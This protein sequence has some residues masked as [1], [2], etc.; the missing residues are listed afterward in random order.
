[1]GAAMV[2][3]M[4]GVAACSS[5][6]T[7]VATTD[8]TDSIEVAEADG[9]AS[10]TDSTDPTDGAMDSDGSEPEISE[11][12]ATDPPS[13]EPEPTPTEPASPA[14]WMPI[15]EDGDCHCADGSPVNFLERVADPTKVVL[16]FEG[17]GACFTAATCEVGGDDQTYTSSSDVTPADLARRGGLFDESNPE[18]P[19][20]D[21]SFVYVPY[22]TGDV[23]LGNTTTEYSPDVV[24]EHRGFPNG[25]AAL[26]HVAA[27]YPDAAQLVVMGA[28]AGS[29]PTP[30][31][32][33]LAADLL[34]ETDIVTFGD[35]SG[36]YPDVPAINETIGA[37]WGTT[38]A[39]P[40]W[41]ENEGL[42]ASD[43]S[44]PDLYVQAG[45]H[46]PGVTFARFDYAFDEVQAFF[47]SLAGVG[48]D[49]VDQQI[50]ATAAQIEAAGVPIATYMAPGTNHTIIGG[51]EF[52]T[53]E[54]NGVRLVDWLAEL[55]NGGVP[56]DVRCEVCT[57]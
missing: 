24:I 22:C 37:V 20:A 30:A 1:M 21:H 14:E 34:P 49:Q 52:Y 12:P 35:S 27:T 54:V 44:F 41:P 25:M 47:A 50:D 33:G 15:L 43:W 26:D 2:V 46:A 51:D 17:G 31:F 8:S 45:R 42:T 28:S 57:T 48:S 10:P 5:D 11:P 56:A 29:V 53:M 36:A 9:G 16:Y 55:I 4:I 38:N 23:H 39:I 40:D 13:T 3:A 7:D 19:L 18:N 32:A 6:S